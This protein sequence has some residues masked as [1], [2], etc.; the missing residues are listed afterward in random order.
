M[1][2]EYIFNLIMLFGSF[3]P[4]YVGAM[5]RHQHERAIFVL[6]AISVVLAL[7]SSQELITVLRV[8]PYPVWGLFGWVATLLWSFFRRVAVPG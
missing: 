5:R 7:G 3:L 1:D 6:N 8:D 4:T 2:A